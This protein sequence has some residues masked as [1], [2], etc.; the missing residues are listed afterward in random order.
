MYIIYRV[1]KEEES[2]ILRK[3][4]PLRIA[5][6]SVITQRVLV[7]PYRRFG[8]TYRARRKVVQKCR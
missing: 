4:V 2:V 5:L 8:I 7:I 1:F 6:F 3:K